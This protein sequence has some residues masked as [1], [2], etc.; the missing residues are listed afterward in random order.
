[1]SNWIDLCL[2]NLATVASG[3]NDKLLFSVWKQLVILNEMYQNSTGLSSEE[4]HISLMV[5]IA[6]CVMAIIHDF[7]LVVYPFAT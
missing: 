1:M 4:L 3:I 7:G 2:L 6:A 5:V